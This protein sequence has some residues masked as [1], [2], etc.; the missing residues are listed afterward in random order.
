MTRAIRLHKRPPACLHASLS[1]PTSTLAWPG[2]IALAVAS[3][4][5]PRHAAILSGGYCTTLIWEC[6]LPPRNTTHPF[7]S[8]HVQPPLA[9]LIRAS[10]SSSEQHLTLVAHRL[11]ELSRP[12]FQTLVDCCRVSTTSIR[13]GRRQYD[14]PPLTFGPH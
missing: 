14:S 4:V 10:S 7:S 3:R 9:S 13:K 11:T 6:M 1:D 8:A 5:Q 12:K 2:P